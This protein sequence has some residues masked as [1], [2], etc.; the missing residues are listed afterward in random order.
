MWSHVVHSSS[1]GWGIHTGTWSQSHG[2]DPQS[3]DE[4]DWTG[5]ESYKHHSARFPFN[6]GSGGKWLAQKSNIFNHKQIPFYTIRSKNI[7]LWKLRDVFR[8]HAWLNV[9]PHAIRGKLSHIKRKE[10]QLSVSDNFTLLF[11]HMMNDGALNILEYK[12][13]I[14]WG[15]DILSRKMFKTT[16]K[17]QNEASFT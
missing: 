11:Q 13:R 6:L 14:K 5:C 1:V 8:T 15:N 17:N 2:N 7:L 4:Q 16:F 10:S 9:V 12:L 3:L